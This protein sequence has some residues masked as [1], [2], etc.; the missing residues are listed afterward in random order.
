LTVVVVVVAVAVAVVVAV[1]YHDYGIE[2]NVV[3]NLH[4]HRLIH[5]SF[6]MAFLVDDSSSIV[7]EIMEI[8]CVSVSML[9]VLLLVVIIIYYID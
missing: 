7:M 9:V 4:H 1:V 8:A 5:Y 3:P 2:T 6:Q